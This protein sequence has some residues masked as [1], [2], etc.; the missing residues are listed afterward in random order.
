MVASLSFEAL[1][2]LLSGSL[3]T[4][5]ELTAEGVRHAERL[6]Y[7]A[8]PAGMHG[9]AAW[10]YLI[11]GS[12]GASQPEVAEAREHA[13]L[14]KSVAAEHGFFFFET[15]ARM[16]D[17]AVS[18]VEGDAGAMAELRDGTEAWRSAG[19]GLGHCWHLTF[20]GFALRR[21]GR[22]DEA[23]ERLE[24]AIVFC[25]TQDSRYFEPEVRRQLAEL[26]ADPENPLWDLELAR[27]E[28]ALALKLAGELDAHWWL[29]AICATSVRLQLEPMA[30]ALGRLLTV[31]RRFTGVSREPPLLREARQLLRAHGM[32]A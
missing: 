9:Q 27:R 11:W 13:R 14:A 8:L 16:I 4:A 28:L 19:A 1:A 18:I 30:D 10:A 21:L 20:I 22:H 6:G 26:L 7:P 5:L 15:Y 17:A 25:E 29:L 12:S 2:E 31:A 24:E 32:T 3:T 23:R